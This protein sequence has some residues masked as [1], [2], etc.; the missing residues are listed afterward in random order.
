MTH[1][2]DPLDLPPERFR[3]L[4]SD[5]LDLAAQWLAAEPDAPVL[6]RPDGAETGAVA[7]RTRLRSRGWMTPRC[8]PTCATRC[9]AIRGATGIRASSR[10]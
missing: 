8:W 7:R 9:C 5:F 6:S 2:N 1:D 3:A 10:T 4:G